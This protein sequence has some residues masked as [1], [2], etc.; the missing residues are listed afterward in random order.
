MADESSTR[1]PVTLEPLSDDEYGNFVEAQIA[2]AA[3]QR[4]EAGEWS[5]SEAVA[6]AHDELGDLIND[7]LRRRGHEFLKGVVNDV[8]CVGRL[9]IAPAP[10]FIEESREAIRW[11]AQITVEESLRGRGYGRAFLTALHNRLSAEGV[12]QLWLRV[13]DWNIAARRL[14]E[15]MGYE[16]V[17]RFETDSH[18]RI[19]LL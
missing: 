1:G 14:Y 5:P 3:R 19:V 15:G 16:T 4:V 12:S 17:R 13:Y 8:G 11:L 10:E 2:E 6:R 18:M 7:R 9:W